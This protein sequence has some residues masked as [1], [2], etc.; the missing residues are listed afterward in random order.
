MNSILSESPLT[1]I[2]ERKTIDGRSD[3]NYYKPEYMEIIKK[4]KNS[5]FNVKKLGDIVSLST[6]RWKK[7]KSGT[8]RYIEINDI[9]TFS[10]QILNA[11]ELNV[12]DAPSR[13][14]MVV[15]KGDIIVSTTR[16]YRGA[17]ALVTEEYDGCVCSTG[18][19]IL[20]HFKIEINRS[21]L[22]YF[23][24][25]NFGLKQMEQRMTGGNYP[26]ILPEE[27]LKIWVPCPPAELQNKIVQLM[28]EALNKKK[29]KEEEA[30]YIYQSI[31]KFLLSVLDISLPKFRAES[32]CIYTIGSKFLKDNRWDSTYWRPDYRRLINALKAS[33]FDKKYLKDVAEVNPRRSV[34]SIEKSDLVPYIGL[35]ETDE[36]SLRIKRILLRAYKDV[37]GRN[38]THLGDI[39]FARIEPS[40]YNK[41]YIFVDNLEGYNYAFIS[42]E[43][44]VINP[45]ED[46]INPIYLYWY[47][48]SGLGYYQIF[49]KLT[50]AT[51]RRRLE[52]RELKSF[53]IILPQ[54]NVQ[55]KVA[56][57][58]KSRLDRVNR[59]RDEAKQIFL[60]A[61]QK[62]E[63]ILVGEEEV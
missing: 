25:S 26:A 45:K 62:I 2:V 38:I 46:K 59:L 16:P 37:K 5:P 15:R 34:N 51:G 29:S 60:E 27:L 17:I 61:K 30:E 8:F 24:H 18:F 39:L 32:P 10:A 7:P 40:I 54:R 63:R 58:I 43:F 19:G 47:L 33:K 23:L 35:P 6:E 48:H 22:L 3:V 49:G 9:N 13:A 52:Q 21:Y 4:L 14:Q 44:H 12:E 50:G 31:N 11:K 41:K 36:K 20:R 55:E 1:F 57:E 53:I 28:E 42:T 56:Q